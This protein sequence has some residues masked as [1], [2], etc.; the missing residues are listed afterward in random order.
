[1]RIRV[2]HDEPGHTLAKTVATAYN[3]IGGVMMVRTKPYE[4]VGHPWEVRPARCYLC[5]GEM[6]DRPGWK[7]MFHSTCYHEECLDIT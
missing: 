1:M 7:T 5:R 6:D 3:R 2:I 4:V